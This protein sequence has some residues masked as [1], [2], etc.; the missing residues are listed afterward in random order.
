MPKKAWQLKGKEDCLT[1]PSITTASEHLSARSY[2]F[3]DYGSSQETKMKTKNWERNWDAISDSE[4]E[5]EGSTEV[6]FSSKPK[7]LTVT[8]LITPNLGSEI[9]KHFDADN[10]DLH[11]YSLTCNAQNFVSNILSSVDNVCKTVPFSGASSE[12]AQN[13]TETMFSDSDNFRR[14]SPS[15][16]HMLYYREDL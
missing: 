7:V 15:S 16:E 10:F 9:S 6:T 12:S 3:S 11:V 4:S 5:S 13:N 8:P 2:S 1:S 14:T